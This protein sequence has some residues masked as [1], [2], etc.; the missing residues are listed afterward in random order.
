MARCVILEVNFP[1]HGEHFDIGDD[2]IRDGAA[3]REEAA[4]CL[5]MHPKHR[6]FYN[7]PTTCFSYRWVRDA[8]GQVY[9]YPNGNFCAF[10]PV[11]T[12]SSRALRNT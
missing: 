12:V 5:G 10:K 9:C 3:A 6:C 11:I 2:T 8:K 4:A 7:D 1:T